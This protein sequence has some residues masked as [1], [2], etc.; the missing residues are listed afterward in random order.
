M[1]D[2]VVLLDKLTNLQFSVS[3]VPEPEIQFF[4]D[5]E[6]VVNESDKLKLVK[7]G[8]SYVIEFKQNDPSNSGTYKVHAKNIVGEA[9]TECQLAVQGNS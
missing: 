9:V 5:N 2:S 8:D 4:A 1:E 3:G 6:L 7:D